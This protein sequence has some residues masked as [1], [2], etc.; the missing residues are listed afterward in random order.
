MKKSRIFKW[1][2]CLSLALVLLVSP[3][4]AQK[5]DNDNNVA[6]RTTTVE[7]TKS[8][9]DHESILNSFEDASMTKEESKTTFIGFQTYDI[10]ELL[11]E[12]DLVSDVNVDTE[13]EA[14]VKYTYTYDEETS[15]VTLAAEMDNNGEIIIDE[16]VGVAFLNEQGEIDAILD[17]DGEEMLLSELQGAGMIENCGWFKN[18]IKKVKKSVVAK[19]VVAV[20]AV[21]AVSAIASVVA[22]AAC[23]AG[24]VGAVVTGAVAG[25][26]VGGAAGAG[27]SYEETGRVS[28]EAVIGGVTLGAIL[29]AATGAAV[30][31]L[32]GVG[33]KAAV[34]VANNANNASKNVKSFNSYDAFKKE[35]GKAKD[36][37][38]DGE[39]HHIVE[40]Q[41]VKNGIN[42]AATI[43]NSQNTVA[44][45]KNL[46]HAVSKYYST[47][48]MN[49]MTYRQYI[50]TLSYADQYANGLK[51]LQMFAEKLGETIIW[52]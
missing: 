52:L 12:I 35:Y 9:I 26:L 46:H 43:Y 2:T 1:V 38:P 42:E 24:M 10:D 37:I 30:G 14:R 16:V 5:I 3:F 7:A 6:I 45:S 36:Y 18:L 51:V 22:V 11:S 4:L 44:I 28:L 48:Y 47:S 29:G 15:L 20:V 13:A 23:G 21:V 32:M 8:Q 39:W 34:Q 27:I 17:I 40:Q 31:K 49:G 50:N 33:T 25:G 19:V 41:T